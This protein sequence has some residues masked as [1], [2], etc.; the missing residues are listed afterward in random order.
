VKLIATLFKKHVLDRG[1][2]ARLFIFVYVPFEKPA[3]VVHPYGESEK[4]KHHGGKRAQER[5][6]YGDQKD[7]R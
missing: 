6:R 7:G 5:E 3:F 2:D 1:V 4:P